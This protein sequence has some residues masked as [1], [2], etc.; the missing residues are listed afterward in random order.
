MPYGNLFVAE[1]LFLF[2]R[3]RFKAVGDTNL[4]IIFIQIKI[5]VVF[6]GEF[7]ANEG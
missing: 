4:P 6:S 5:L 1:L 2:Y 7:V 3:K